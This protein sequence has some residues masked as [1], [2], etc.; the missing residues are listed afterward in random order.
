M[1]LKVQGLLGSYR[2]A[3][4]DACMKQEKMNCRR[5]MDFKFTVDSC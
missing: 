4:Q 1:C 2:L 3:F 5:R